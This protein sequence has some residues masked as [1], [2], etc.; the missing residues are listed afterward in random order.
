MENKDKKAVI[1][2]SKLLDLMSKGNTVPEI[3]KE[4]EVSEGKIREAAKLW[5]IN[6]RKK[7]TSVVEFV[8]DT[9]EEPKKDNTVTY[10][11]PEEKTSFEPTLIKNTTENLEL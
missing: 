6:L 7:P 4:F 1:T 5:D 8:D 3:A 9:E 2:K 11:E 10:T